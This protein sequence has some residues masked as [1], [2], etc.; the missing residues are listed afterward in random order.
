MSEDLLNSIECFGS[1][2]GKVG[3]D[4]SDFFQPAISKLNTE[5]KNAKKTVLNNFV[6]NLGKPRAR[7]LQ[8]SDKKIGKSLNE[9]IQR[10]SKPKNYNPS[11]KRTKNDNED[12]EDNFDYDRQIRPKLESIT[13]SSIAKQIHLFRGAKKP[14]QTQNS[15]PSEINH[16]IKKRTKDKQYTREVKKTKREYQSD[17]SMIEVG[18]LSDIE[19]ENLRSQMMG[20]KEDYEE[21]QK[22]KRRN[23]KNKS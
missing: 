20:R 6:K 12:D 11:S 1:R 17:D 15:Q 14:V 21:Y 22:E 10:R 8:E 2:R 3:L 18:G 19:E 5:E 9:I 23:N 16:Q 4:K 13:P 7:E